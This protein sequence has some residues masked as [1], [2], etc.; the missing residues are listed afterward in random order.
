MVESDPIG[1]VRQLFHYRDGHAAVGFKVFQ[2]HSPEAH[3]TL[4]KDEAIHKIILKRE[5]HLASFSSRLI[6]KET[7]QWSTSNPNA[8]KEAKAHFEAKPFEN[9]CR[10][11]D[12]YF[13]FVSENSRGPRLDIT[14][15]DHIMARKLDEVI[16]FLGAD[17]SVEIHSDKVKQLSREV[18]DRFDNP[19]EVR[20]HLAKTNHEN[21]ARE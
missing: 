11:A 13:D 1:F 6:A 18:V 3:E 15:E 9:F 12:E 17:T 8:R 16:E 4:L 20:D 10:R 7:G 5:N 2:G 14:Y 19:E 21:W